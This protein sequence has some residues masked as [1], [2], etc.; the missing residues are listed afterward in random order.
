MA[1]TAN[2]CR[3]ETLSQTLSGEAEHC[4]LE[5]DIVQLGIFRAQN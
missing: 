4:L 5:S 1:K 3:A 2:E